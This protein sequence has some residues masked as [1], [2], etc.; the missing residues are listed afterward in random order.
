MSI[1]YAGVEGFLNVPV[2]GRLLVPP[3]VATHGAWA[4]VAAAAIAAGALALA[5][6]GRADHSE[7]ASFADVEAAIAGAGLEVCDEIE[8]EARTRGP[9]TSGATTWP[10]TAATTTR[11][12]R[13]WW[14]RPTRTRR[15]ATARRG[16][17]RRQVR[18]PAQ[19]ALWTLG[20]LTVRV[21]GD[22]DPDA[23]DAL[24]EALDDRGAE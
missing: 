11:T 10:S 12:T 21:S 15:T 19:G 1:L 6:C 13:S 5:G 8:T 23:V 16:A 17:S 24:T 3:V 4:A 18:P 22:R 20:P 2:L 14:R 7:P 9:T